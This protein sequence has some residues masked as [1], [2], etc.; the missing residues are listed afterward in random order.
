MKK[1]ILTVFLLCLLLTITLLLVACNDT[2][3]TPTPAP[4]E[5][6]SSAGA[7]DSSNIQPP[8]DSKKASEGLQYTFADDGSGYIVAGIGTCSDSEI[9]IPAV[10]QDKPVVKLINELFRGKTYITGVVL[11][12]SIT[13]I[14]DSVFSGCTSLTSITIP[15]SVTSIGNSA[16]YGCT[17][18]TSITIPNS[19]TIIRGVAFSGCTSLTSITIPDSVTSIEESAFY[20]C[21]IESA[22]IPLF[23][24]SY[25]DKKTLKSV[26]ITNGTSIGEGAFSGC[27]NLTS[28]TIPNSVTNIGNSAFYGC[29]SLR[30]VTIPNSVTS[31]GYGASFGG[32]SALLSMLNS[33]AS[34]V[35]VVNIDNGFGAGYLA[36]MMNHM[37]G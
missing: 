24:C 17:S 27:T 37:R 20:G 3:D 22:T 9:I 34:G 30:S 10:Y 33:C 6:G 16:F 13:D 15:D 18:L 7:D 2:C 11:P 4:E 21:T 32:V 23:V 1:Q 36:S 25:I 26:V 19:V 14:G 31:I 28:V 12:N 5:P 8:S 29:R 35:S